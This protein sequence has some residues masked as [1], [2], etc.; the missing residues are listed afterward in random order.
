MDTKWFDA[1][2][3]REAERERALEKKRVIYIQSSLYPGGEFVPELEARLTVFDRGFSIGDSAYEYARTYK[4]KPMQLAEHMDRMFS[5]LKVMRLNPGVGREKFA[6]L[7]EEL[8]KRNAALLEDFEEYNVV[9]EVTRGEWG[10]HGRRTPSPEGA[11]TPT[12]IIKN[13]LNDQRLCAHYFSSGVHVVTPPGRHVS[14]QAWDPKIK[15]YSR[16]NY[17][18]ADFEARLVDPYATALMLDESGNLSEAIGANVWIVLDGVLM[19]PTDR[20]IL[21]GQNRNNVIGFAKKLNIPLEFKDLQPWHLYNCQEAFL[22]TTYPG[23]FQ[24]IGR[25]NGLLVGKELPGPVTRRLADAWSEW[26]GIDVTGWSRL[27]R[28]EK[29]AAE[30]SRAALNAERGALAHI[31]Y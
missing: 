19:T 4:H 13:N 1:E 28:E 16:L 21:R 11:A 20:N 31:P 8:T 17:V 14:P 23:P 12:V 7:C 29:A 3:N 24:P 6:G 30:K 9:W 2:K 15:T 18:L 27:N 25:F 26:A 10:W 5:S 22:T